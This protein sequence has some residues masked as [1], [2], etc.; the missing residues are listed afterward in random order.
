MPANAIAEPSFR[1][2]TPDDLETAYALSSEMRWPHRLEDWAL[3]LRHGEGW[4][5]VEDDKVV[6]T[7]ITWNWGEAYSTLGMV[8]VAPELQGRRIGYQMMLRLI[9]QAGERRVMLCATKEGQGLYERLGFVARGE[10]LQCQGITTS[11][12]LIEQPEGTRLRP[13]GRADIAPLLALDLHA[14]GMDRSRLLR[15]L[16]IDEEA[17]VLERDGEPVG[18]SLARRFGRGHAIGPVVAPDFAGA[19][20]LVAHWVGRH[21]GRFVRIDIERGSGL[22]DWVVSLGLVQV[23]AVT[24]MG[25]GDTPSRATADGFYAL[26]SQALG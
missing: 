26:I 13:M 24:V 14:A 19:Q 25:R 18:F 6:A 10:V 23:G 7:G 17:V 11:A 20:A 4:V 9:A 3:M 2:M 8:I 12:P 1:R 15:P 16:L 22:L 5:A 21:A